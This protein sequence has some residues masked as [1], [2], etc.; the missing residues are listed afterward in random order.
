M[1]NIRINPVMIDPK[2]KVNDEE[3]NSLIEENKDNY[4]SSNNNNT[5]NGFGNTFGISLKS[6]ILLYLFIIVVI[7]FA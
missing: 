2:D 1:S 6:S 7:F 5:K 4:I 3:L